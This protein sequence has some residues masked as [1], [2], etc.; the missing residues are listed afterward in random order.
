MIIDQGLAAVVAAIV[1]AIVAVISLVV[2]IRTEK[3][4]IY[5]ESRLNLLLGVEQE[6]RN[7]FYSQ[8]SEFYD[9]IFSLL[10]VNR[11]NFNRIGPN[12]AA[13]YSN[14]FPE[15]ETA[16]VWNKLVRQV[17]TPNNL[18][19]CEII[20]TKLHLLAPGDA[21]EPYMDFITHAYAYHVFREK[22]YEAYALFQF[23]QGFFEHVEVK[24]NGLRQH[25]E[26]VLQPSKQEVG[27]I[28]HGS[29]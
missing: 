29:V 7:L 27:K 17:I 25:L 28:K 15:N 19:V 11:K 1:A 10:S 4:R 2:S 9:P 21:V 16:E 6:K 3:E 18:K 14:F 13:R 8:L 20:Q 12:S 22:P 23:P 24:R 5:L 26:K